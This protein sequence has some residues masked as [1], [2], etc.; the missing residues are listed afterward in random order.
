MRSRGLLQAYDI[1]DFAAKAANELK[2][3]PVK[4]IQ[5]QATRA[6]A[7][8]NLSTVWVDASERIRII[9]GRPMP[10]SLRPTA[11]SNSKSK[12]TG[13]G[14][15][16]PVTNTGASDSTREEQPFIDTA[17]RVI[18]EQPAKPGDTG[19]QPKDSGDKPS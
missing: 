15:R 13:S 16:G 5:D 8:R 6:L 2:D 19:Q 12:P 1:R 9:R 11:K 4:S 17:D 14:S 3:I 7:L 10:G 18:D